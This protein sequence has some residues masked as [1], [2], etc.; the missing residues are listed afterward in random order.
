MAVA[1][2]F[3]A[4]FAVNAQFELQILHASDLEGGV[5][6]IDRAPRFAALVD[7]LE[8]EYANTVVLSAG[9]NYIPGPFYNAAG[10]RSVFRD[11]GVFNDTYN[12][13][14]GI[15]DYDAL[16]E[17]NGRVDI[18]IMNI[19]GFDASAIGNHEFDAGAD[20]MESIIE[21][22]FR[23]PAG[24][25]ADRWVGAQF[26]YLSAN[27]DF[28]GSGDL[29]NIFTSDLL[30][31]TDFATGPDQST[32]ENSSVPKVAPAT[33]IDVNGETIGV[34][35]ATTPIVASISSPGE[36]TAI[37]SGTNDMTELAAI[38]QPTIDAIEALGVDKIILVSHLQ[39]FALEQELAGLLSGVDVIIAG[40]SDT[41]LANEDDDLLPEDEANVGGDYPFETTNSDAEPVYIVSTNG[42]YSYVGRLV[43]NFDANGVVISA[44]A[45]SGPYVSTD[46]KVEEI[47]GNLVDPF[48]P[49]TKAS[50]VQILVDAVTDIVIEKDG[51]TFGNTDV[52]LDGR[53]S[54]VRTEETN[55]GNLTADAN[56][57]FAQQVDETV[58]VSHKNGGGI[59]AAIG[60][61]VDLGEG[62]Y[63]FLPPQDN[64]LSGKEEGEVSQLDIENSLRFNN[65]LTLLTLS[66]EGLKEVIEHSVA[67]SGDGATPGQFGQ[68]GG[69]SFSFDPSLE[70]GSRVQNAV[71]LDEDRN[72]VEVLVR[73]GEVEGDPE[74]PIRI[75]SLN[76]LVGGGDSYPFPE[77]GS[78]IVQLSDEG[79]IPEEVVNEGVAEFANAGTEQDALA[80][81][82]ADEFGDDPFEGEE[83]PAEEDTRIQNLSLR[84]DNVIPGLTA[85]FVEETT[86]VSEEGSS[87]M[88]AVEVTNLGEGPAQVGLMASPA[89]T[90]V[91]GLNYMMLGDA[92]E[93]PVGVTEIMFEVAPMDDDAVG[94]TFL[95]LTFSEG[96]MGGD[97]DVHTVLFGDNDNE[98][99]E[100]PAFPGIEMNVLASLETPEGAVAEISAHDPVSQRLFVTN[101]ED[102]Q[103]LVFDFSDPT[104]SNI[105]NTIEI[106]EFGGGINSVAVSNG[107]VAVAVEAEDTGVRG[108]VLFLDTD[109][110]FLGEAEAGFLPD[111]VTFTPDGTKVLTANEGEP[112]DDYEIDPEGSISIIDISGG[113]ESAVIT[114]ATF[115]A[116][117]GME[118]DLR[119]QGVR[120]FGPEASASQDLE[121][122]YITVS[123]DGSTAYVTLQENN[124]VAVV[125][126][127]SSTVSAILPLGYKDYSS[128]M[129]QID[130][131]NRSNGLFM[132]P[133][134]NVVGMYQPDAITSVVI[135]GQEY[136]ITAN[137]GDARDYDG[138]SEEVRV[139]DLE[140]DETAFPYADIL[141]RDEL[142]GRLK[143]TTA[144]GDT[145][146]DGDYDVIYNYGARSFTIW[147]ASDGSMVYDSK[148]DLESITSQ[149]PLWGQFFNSTDDELEFMNRSD[150]KGPEPENVITGVIGD[151][152]YA[153]VIL[154]RIGGVVAYDISNPMEPQFIQYLNNRD[155]EEDEGGDL[156]PEG[157]LF[158]E[159]ED[160]PT[161]GNILVISN[162]VS[163]TI[164]VISLD[165]LEQPVAPDCEDLDIYL[166][167]V[168]EDGTTNIYEV[169]LVE[170]EAQ[171]EFI[172]ASEFE[173]HIAYNDADQLI[174]AVS[175][176]DGSYRTL[177][178]SAESPMF[179]EVSQLQTPL[180]DVTQAAF[181]QDGKLILGS[182][183]TK[184]IYSVM[185]DDNSVSVYDSYLPLQGGDVVV[186]GAGALYS[187]SRLGFGSL[188]KVFPEEIM[189]DV[190]V[191]SVPAEVTGLALM[192]NGNFLVSHRDANTMEV[193]GINGSEFEPY[194]VTLAGESFFTMFGDLT[195][196]CADVVVEE[197]SDEEVAQLVAPISESAVERNNNLISFPNPTEGMSQVIFSSE[198]EG[199]V[200]VEVFDLNG[201]LVEAIFNQDV[202]AGV[203]YRVDFNGLK[204]PNGVYVYKMKTAKETTVEKFMIAR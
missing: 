42:E 81:Y 49:G 102:N 5:E 164:T 108:S 114:E 16:R 59:R 20:A 202:E 136:L 105:I 57:W 120:I 181:N 139:D 8:D 157:I 182:Q 48:A 10:E 134:E 90:A 111:M 6:A 22:D 52:F 97:E 19:I 109:G 15:G 60:E 70:P 135:D 9:D 158:V 154:E 85:T 35:G 72:P 18:S 151:K 149:D 66:A 192:P 32:A 67:A 130:A 133:W 47:W 113:I 86:W 160:S 39:Q 82:L 23:S 4:P 122:E 2:F 46:D 187:A 170:D 29:G 93:V 161:G 203:E 65:G 123:A 12:T 96:V 34:V 89:S 117:D 127:E 178:P 76:F 173:V 183:E 196:G 62:E 78:D 73:N 128:V 169:N 125:D 194:S 172:A 17:G 88:V 179:G 126:I 176:E 186:D 53:R 45:D 3:M 41:I 200:T 180:E 191:G 37:G 167:D 56:L 198:T 165:E 132:A 159:A 30:F 84:A 14:F 55:L 115:E 75:V 77:L 98:I 28:S 177:D 152:T 87:V 129:N 7:A 110:N 1:A 31:N 118:D 193:R 138:F 44:G 162:E 121:P 80:E 43:V 156:A 168:L 204:L 185:L 190:L 33:L 143:T 103:L 146:G 197:E 11:A 137:E 195:S 61:I 25:T 26:P 71:L 124:A 142:L 188:Y 63:S 144:N 95:A 40:G 21:E 199:R 112:D 140:L 91:E 13:L 27:L 50:E 74:R 189:E 106:D 150:D 104:V 116:F 107:I 92:Q 201:R 58:Q 24:P 94:S 100:A 175:N 51:N 69:L 101:S 145:D 166:A 64:P 99:V 148:D 153:F 174:Y 36:V 68:W 79:V 38:L 184:A 54:Q 163:G 141:Q 147:N 171:L 131:S 83:T 119:E 155:P